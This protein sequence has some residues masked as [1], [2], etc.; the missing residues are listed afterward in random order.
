MPSLSED[1]HGRVK[2]IT[3]QYKNILE[4][5]LWT[6]KGVKA[7]FIGNQEAQPIFFKA[8]TVPFSMKS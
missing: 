3:S 4:K 7:K 5:Y 8:R 6:I 1:V 2:E